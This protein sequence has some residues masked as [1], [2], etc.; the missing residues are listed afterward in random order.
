MKVTI[1]LF[2]RVTALDAIGPYEVL[3]RVPGWE[4]EF[5]AVEAGPVRTDTGITTIGATRSISEIDS[6]DI[7]LIPGG[8][9]SRQLMSDE[10]TLEWLR[11]VAAGADWT[12]SV[13]TGSLVLA[14]AGLLDGKRCTTHWLYLERLRELGAVPVAERVVVD[15][16]TITA[17]GVSSGIDMALSLVGRVCGPELAQTIQLG[18]EY[19]PQPPYESGSPR[20]APAETVELVTSISAEGDRWLA[21]RQGGR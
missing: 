13:C 5:A 6:T 19:D 9:G 7:L 4:L 8:P 1:L 20:T 11:A 10:P 18:I 12:A 14:A 2:D 16:D 17:A 3:S 21:E 15:G